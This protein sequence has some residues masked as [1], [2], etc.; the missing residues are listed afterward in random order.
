MSSAGRERTPEATTPESTPA[1]PTTPTRDGRAAAVAS[2]ARWALERRDVPELMGAGVEAIARGLDVEVA[3]AFEL[4]EGTGM[5]AAWASTGPSLEG[6]ALSLAQQAAVALQADGPVT[7]D[8]GAETL[9]AVVGVHAGIAVVVPGPDG[10]AFGVL[11]AQSHT[12]RSFDEHDAAFLQSVANVLGLAVAGTAASD[13]SAWVEGHDPVTGLPNRRHLLSAIDEEIENHRRDVAVVSI[14]LD[15][16]ERVL[17]DLGGAAGDEVL[18]AVARRLRRFAGAGDV[19]AR[20]GHH[21]FALL[22]HGPSTDE[23]V[24][25]LAV[26]V[27]ETVAK[28]LRTRAGAGQLSV[29]A[30][31]GAAVA[32]ADDTPEGLVAAADL[33]VQRARELGRNRWFVFDEA[34]RVAAREVAELEHALRDGIPRDELRLHYQPI[35]DLATGALRGAEALVRW[36]HPTRGLLAPDL[37]IPLAERTG[38]VVPLGAWVLE[39]AG[40]QLARWAKRGLRLPELSVNLS[41]RQLLEGDLV[42]V[43]RRVVETNGLDARTLCLEVTENALVDDPARIAD[44]LHALTEIGVR[45]SIDDF[46]TGYSSLGQLKRFPLAD[47]LK[48]DRSFVDGVGRDPIDDVIIA[49]VVGLARGWSAEVVAE[50]IERS[51]QC[52]M[53]AARGVGLG[54]GYLWS[55]PVP[56]DAFEALVA[57]RPA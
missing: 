27:T 35:V 52:E 17:H 32:A 23:E 7:L 11:C 3:Q 2:L 43:V 30:S 47:V 10:R 21:A 49:A 1:V 19:V 14:V 6:S 51:E 55:P 8:A 25:E 24:A 44:T 28:P 26:R 56:A 54:Q 48:I 29:T 40:R 5:L 22:V 53:L 37:F 31:V 16:F 4:L 12:A 45:I 36:E 9:H 46:G 57:A 15:L 39:E 34:L 33:A 41:P 18:R 38:L 20:V 13:R 50:G 42:A